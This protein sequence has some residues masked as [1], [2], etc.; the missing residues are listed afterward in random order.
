MSVHT[1]IETRPG[2]PRWSIGLAVFV[3]L[4]GGVYAASNLSGTN[5]PILGAPSPGASGT[6]N[7]AAAQALIARVT[8]SCTTCH[9]TDLSGQATF[10]SLHGLQ[11]GPTVDNLQ[12][13]GKDHPNDWMNIWITGTDPA[14]SDPAMRK[15]MPAFGAAPNNLSPDQ[16]ETI[17]RYLLTLQ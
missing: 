13:L 12:K 16:I 2:L 11:N 5:A 9:G 14:V 7:V 4:V 10:P 3:F 15:G 17:V 8:P 1:P 6:V